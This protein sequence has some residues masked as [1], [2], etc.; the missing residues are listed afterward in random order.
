MAEERVAEI[1]EDKEPKSKSPNAPKKKKGLLLI[2]IAGLFFIILLAAGSIFFFAPSIIP[3][4]IH[5]FKEEVSKQ[6]KKPEPAKQ[7]HIYSLDSMIVNLADAEFSRFL[8]I[9]IHLESEESKPNEEYDKRL[10]QLKDAILTILSNKTYSEIS[11]SKGKMKLK[12]EIGLKAN[13]LFEKFKV[14][15]VY[16]TEFVIQ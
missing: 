14:R 7:G 11:D 3:A 10:A 1:K 2:I 9:K 4:A 5:P 8:K 13:Q 6:E 15:T 16:F 12:E